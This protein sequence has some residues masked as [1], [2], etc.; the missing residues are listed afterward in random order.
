MSAFGWFGLRRRNMWEPPTALDKFLASPLQAIARRAYHFILFLRGRPFRASKTKPPIRVV[1][2]SDTH[3]KTAPV[4]D[5]DL[6]IH[7]GDLTDPGTIDAIQVQIDWLDSL[8]H[9][10][11]VFVCGNHDS[12]FDPAS[13]KIDDH[14]SRRTPDYKSL[15]YLQ[16]ASVT[17]EFEG[18][19]ELNVYGAGDVPLCGGSAFA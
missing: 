1:C 15:H 5:G 9:R 8:P 7:A 14:D 19:R 17:L 10:H 16:D 12:W 11:K 6:L 13:R 4:P 3:D 2:I 18:G